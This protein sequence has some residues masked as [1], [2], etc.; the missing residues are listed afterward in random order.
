MG[1]PVL[2]EARSE[3]QRSTVGATSSGGF[4]LEPE[5]HNNI[6]M[7]AT[8][9]GERLSVGESASAGE[10]ARTARPKNKLV[11]TPAA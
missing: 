10:R 9:P 8:L 1:S 6:E 7:V 3:H 11:E 5:P 2:K 4:A